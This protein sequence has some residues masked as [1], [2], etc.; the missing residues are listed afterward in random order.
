AATIADAELAAA[1]GREREAVVIYTEVLANPGLS[2][3]GR[4]AALTARAELHNW[5]RDPDA[6]LAD[7]TA[8]IEAADDPE[9]KATA[10]FA[11]AEIHGRQRRNDEAL[12]DYAET[13]RLMP[14][15]A[16][17]HFARAQLYR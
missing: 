6:A 7:L 9:A 17:A 5:L 12:A 14:S 13:I 2:N 10:H 8:A 3:A 11:R 1:E 16:G 15:F 4:A